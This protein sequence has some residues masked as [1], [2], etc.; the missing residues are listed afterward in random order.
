MQCNSTFQIS[1]KQVINV[2]DGAVLGYV[3]DIEF[4]ICDGRITAFIVGCQNALGFCK[5]ESFRV[6]WCDIKC[7]GEETILV[8]ILPEK[9]RCS[10]SDEKK[11]KKTNKI[12]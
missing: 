8:E 3:T 5:G 9:C 6:P 2:C 4:D 12:I 11:K 7:V 10:L 1:K